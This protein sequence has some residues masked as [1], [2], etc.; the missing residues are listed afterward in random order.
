MLRLYLSTLLYDR[1]IK[2]VTIWFQN[3]RQTTR[4]TALHNATNYSNNSRAHAD[5]PHRSSSRSSLDRPTSTRPTLDQIATLT[6][7]PSFPYAEPPKTP[8]ARNQAVSPWDNMLSSPDGPVTSPSTIKSKE[9]VKWGGIGRGRRTLEWAC[10]NA[11]VYGIEEEDCDMV[12]SVEDETDEDSEVIT[13][14][15]SLGGSDMDRAL[16]NRVS[17]AL[18]GERDDDVTMKDVGVPEVVH[19]EDMMKAAL[20]LCGLGRG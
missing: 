2:T 17:I 10:A 7:L 3:R 14:R 18:E 12:Q 11:R 4:K 13:P 19:D 9:F 15:S 16:H 1:D 8:R 20:A 6:E 5:P